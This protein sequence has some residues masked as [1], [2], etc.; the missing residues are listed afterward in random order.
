MTP[1]AEPQEASQPQTSPIQTPAASQPPAPAAAA[2]ASLTRG[3]PISLEQMRAALP[4]N[5]PRADANA[6]R[7]DSIRNALF[8]AQREV[9]LTTPTVL[10]LLNPDSMKSVLENPRVQAELPSLLEHLP[11]QDRSV[12]RIEEI[13]RSP[14]LRAQLAALTHAL[15]SGEATE[16]IRSFDL[17]DPPRPGLFGLQTFIEALKELER[18]SK[19]PEE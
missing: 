1:T 6:N 18:Q 3:M 11:E 12:D 19:E 13:L 5:R 16:L 8:E 2:P 9:F 15:Q 14:P 10:D 4:S 17:P 7:N